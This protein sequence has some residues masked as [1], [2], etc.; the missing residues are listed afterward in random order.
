MSYSLTDLHHSGPPDLLAGISGT[1]RWQHKRETIMGKW[2]SYIGDMPARRAPACE[3]LAEETFA[4]YS[5]LHIR[6][7]SA[8]ED[9]VTAYLLLPEDYMRERD[10]GFAERSF[11]AVIALHQ[12][13]PAGKAETATPEGSDN[14]RY[15]LELVL[16]GYVVLA[17][18]TITAGERAGAQPYHTASFYAQYPEWTAVGKMASDHLHGVDLLCSL[19]GVDAGRIGAIGHSL[20]GYNSFFLAG[21]DPRIRAFVSSCGFCTFAGDPEPNR[22]GQRDWFSHIPRLT[23]DLR[24]DRVPFELH[25]IAALAAPTPAFYWSGQQDGIFPHW[26]SYSE[27]MEQLCRLYRFLGAESSFLYLLGSCGHDFPGYARAIAYD[28]LDRWLRDP[29]V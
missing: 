20:G 7:R 16:R 17:P 10:N 29:S 28:F 27:G 13:A 3:T 8:Y 11:P 19:Q 4:G 5:R 23:A 1:E 9:G 15:G 6:Y 14:Q 18:D 26:R 22:W 2:L 24:E 21:L 12:T 25:E